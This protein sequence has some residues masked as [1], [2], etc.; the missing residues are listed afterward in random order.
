MIFPL[1]RGINSNRDVIWINTAED[2]DSC[3]TQYFGENM[4]TWYK[5]KWG[6]DGH[7]GIDI[8]CLEG[9]DIIA[10]HKGVVV[11]VQDTDISAGYGVKLW[12]KN[13]N[14]KTIYWHNKRNVVLLGQN[15]EEGQ[16]IAQADNTGW[17]TGTHLH[18]GCKETDNQGNTIN[19]KNGYNG[20]IDPMPF[21]T[22]MVNDEILKLI[23]EL[24]FY[25][26]PDKEANGYIGKDVK[27]VLE[28]IVGSKEHEIYKDLYEAGKKLEEFG[29]SQ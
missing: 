27:D 4:L 15:I 24:G 26:L 21:L 7:N 20:A 29:K 8:R 2:R 19:R 11:Q 16:T 25:R 18:W 5:E 3:I 10:S 22:T 14:K 17:S 28:L 1:K 23:Y 6:L 12:D 13:T 9:E